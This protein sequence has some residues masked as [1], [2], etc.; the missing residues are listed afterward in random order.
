MSHWY[1]MVL[2]IQKATKDV[3]TRMHTLRFLLLAHSFQ[4][5]FS[6]P[7]QGLLLVHGQLQCFFLHI[8]KHNFHRIII[9]IHCHLKA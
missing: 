9:V 7:T 4:A 8:T 5:H 3:D 1:L 6:E 2:N